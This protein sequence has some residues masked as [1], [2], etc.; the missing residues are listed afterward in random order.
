MEVGDFEIDVQCHGF[1]FRW[2]VPGYI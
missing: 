2:S 1:E